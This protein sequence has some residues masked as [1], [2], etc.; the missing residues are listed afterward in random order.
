[1]VLLPVLTAFLSLGLQINCASAADFDPARATVLSVVSMHAYGN[2]GDPMDLPCADQ[3]PCCDLAT[4]EPCVTSIS[5]DVG[6]IPQLKI[7]DSA[8]FLAIPQSV[9]EPDSEG[10]GPRLI[11]MTGTVPFAGSAS[12]YRRF[13]TYLE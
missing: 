11:P 2:Q 4:I 3:A 10:R 6:S 8:Q 5:D 9:P 12:A 1:M 13:C 7:K